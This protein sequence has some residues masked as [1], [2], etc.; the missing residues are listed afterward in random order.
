MEILKETKMKN[1][2]VLS[3]KV[4][5]G[6]FVGFCAIGL[7]WI[8][9]HKEPEIEVSSYYYI[10]FA[11][12]TSLAALV[13]FIMFLCEMSAVIKEKNKKRIVELI[14]EI[15]IGAIVGKIFIFDD[16]INSIVIWGLSF[17]ICMVAFALQFWKRHTT[18]E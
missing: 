11:I 8:M 13:F 12:V 7:I 18:V 9:I 14:A 6:I 15:I 10:P 17:G 16:D 1:Y 2:L 3:S 5:A 4:L